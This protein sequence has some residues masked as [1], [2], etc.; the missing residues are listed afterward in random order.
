VSSSNEWIGLVGV[1]GGA[2]VAVGSAALNQHG[3][4]SARKQDRLDD[5]AEG[6]QSWRREAY[7][8]L[9][10][11]NVKMV[12]SVE[13]ALEDLEFTKHLGGLS[14]PRKF[15]A[16]RERDTGLYSEWTEAK[17]LAQLVASDQVYAAI[18]SYETWLGTEMGTYAGNPE[19]CTDGVLLD[20][21]AVTEA[22]VVAMRADL[23]SLKG[24]QDQQLLPSGA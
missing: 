13:S 20:G 15:G 3:T 22:L 2:L 14:I 23:Q 6:R 11:A 8:N 17:H 5:R 19:L 7:S 24:Q 1:L 4:A 12:A 16:L 9:L 10:G 21:E 18:D